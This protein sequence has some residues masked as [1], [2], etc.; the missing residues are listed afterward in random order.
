MTSATQEAPRPNL[1]TQA[2]NATNKEIRVPRSA[3]ANQVIE[4]GKKGFSPS[5]L[6]RFLWG[7]QCANART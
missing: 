1:V 6:P 3:E 2:S 5:R 4:H 7:N